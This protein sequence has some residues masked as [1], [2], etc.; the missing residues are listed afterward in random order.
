[1]LVVVARFRKIYPSLELAEWEVAMNE[2][3]ARELKLAELNIERYRRLLRSDMEADK[4]RQILRL[5]QEAQADETRLLRRQFF[6]SASLG[7]KTIATEP[8][9]DG[10][11]MLRARTGLRGT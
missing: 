9:V 2:V 6:A 1:S 8:G 10:R 11:S 7:R 3:V 5:L 4:R